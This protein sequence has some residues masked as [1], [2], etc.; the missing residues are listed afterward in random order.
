VYDIL[1]LVVIFPLA[2]VGMT[3]V[4]WILEKISD[5]MGLS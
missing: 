2:V 5:A 4:A 3:V 1:T